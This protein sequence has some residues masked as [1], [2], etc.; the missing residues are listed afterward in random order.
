MTLK[1]IIGHEI[2]VKINRKAIY[3]IVKMISLRFRIHLLSKFKTSEFRLA[4][5]DMRLTR[6]LLVEVSDEN[7]VSS[8]S[9]FIFKIIIISILYPVYKTG[10]LSFSFD[11]VKSF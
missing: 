2:Q 1:Y 10:R 9:L 7:E 6:L 4:F 5:L 3:G 11:F 8:I